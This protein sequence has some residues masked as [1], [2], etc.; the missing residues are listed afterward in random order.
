MNKV[1]AVHIE[2]IFTMDSPDVETK[3]ILFKDQDKAIQYMK[4]NVQMNFL[5]EMSD[6]CGRDCSIMDLN[7][8][9]K[10]IESNAPEIESEANFSAYIT[11]ET[12][13]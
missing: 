12:V 5:E 4:T 9:D 10:S 3:I 13:H 11:E 1:Y 8:Q 7:V 6:L 2:K